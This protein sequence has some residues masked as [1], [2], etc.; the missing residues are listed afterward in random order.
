MVYRRRNVSFRRQKWRTDVVVATSNFGHV[1]RPNFWGIGS[2]NHAGDFKKKKNV[3]G[4]I[5][6]IGRRVEHVVCLAGV[7]C[8]V[9]LNKN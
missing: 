1:V 8:N 2:K 5:G 9:K 6:T 3:L 4:N 7:F